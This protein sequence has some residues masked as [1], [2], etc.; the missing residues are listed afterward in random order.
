M[1]R[2]VISDRRRTMVWI[3][4]PPLRSNHIADH[5]V[6]PPETFFSIIPSIFRK[7]KL[8]FVSETLMRS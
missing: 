7:G 1:I 4:A 8:I 3:C 5:I 2:Y 6:C